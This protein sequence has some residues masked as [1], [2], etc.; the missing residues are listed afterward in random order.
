MKFKSL[1]CFATLLALSLVGCGSSSQPHTHSYDKESAEWVW[2]DNSSGGYDAKVIFTCT[3][4][5]EDTEG[6]T[7]EVNANVESRQTLAPTCTTAGTVLYTATATFE[8]QTFTATKEKTVSD[9][10]AHHFAEVA[11]EAYLKSPATCTED[12]VYYKSCEFCHEK[13]EETFTVANSKLGHHLVHH[14]A[15]ESTCQVQGN[16]EYYECDRCG[17]LFLDESASNETTIDDVL[18]PTAHRYLE[19]AEEAYLKSPAT[20]TEDAVYYKSC[21][22][23]HEKNEE[24]FTVANSKLGHHLIHHQAA[25]STCQVQGNIE[26]YECDRCNKLFLDENA[27]N[28]TTA[29]NVLLPLTHKM[30]YHAG[31]NAT[32][33]ADGSHA[34]YTCEYEDGVLYKDENANEKYNNAS[35]LVIDKLGHSFDESLKCSR[36]NR[37]L[38][39]E[40]GMSD[41]TAIDG[42][43]PVTVSNLGFTSGSYMRTGSEGHT[44]LDYNFL[45]NGGADIWM[46]YRYSF[47]DGNYD[48][49]SAQWYILNNHSED[50]LRIRLDS[51]AEN[52][53]IAVLYVYSSG[54]CNNPG[55]DD[56]ILS[57]P[58]GSAM[59]FFPRPSQFKANT[60]ITLH[61]AITLT[62]PVKN[63]FNVKIEAGSNGTLYQTSTGAESGDYSPRSFNIEMGEDFTGWVNKSIRFTAK[64]SEDI[65]ISDV[66]SAESVLVYKDAAG[67]IV[68]K[69]DNPG[70]A[71]LP[72]LVANNKTFIGWFDPQGNRIND[73]DAITTKKIV[74]PRFVD[75]QTNMFVPSDTLGN[76]FAAAKGGWYESTAFGGE[77]GGQLPTSEVN[78]RYDVYFIYQFV[79]RS[80]GDNYAIFGFPFDFIDAKTRVH[81][82]IDNPTNGN[83]V[84]YIYGGATN[85]GGAGGAGT[86]FSQAGFRSNGANLLVHMAIY[87]ASVNGFTLL[88]EITNLGDGQV[89]QTTREVT[90]NDATL[91]AIDSPTRN[92]FDLMK[93]NC[94]YRITDAF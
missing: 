71:K 6:H 23:C 34:Y 16:I 83:L 80:N 81:L 17:I 46:N 55:T 2:K 93:A 48:E 35:E 68:G 11:E 15:A 65:T 37:T 41:A 36:C 25:E 30:T 90:F 91:Y 45:A 76:E 54:Q 52:D 3:G 77:C 24:T 56:D 28:E 60:D 7:T 79:S 94:E 66:A 31:S 72:A 10:S 29:Q 21:E 32:C 85:L 57:G 63:I 27:T 64:R 42:I 1:F 61:F 74:T 87:Y 59:F 88:V 44:F 8:G 73:G 75:S 40:Y 22:F 33:T 38:K 67:N 89:Y 19:V 47:A 9:S 78:D 82:R 70:T 26:Y 39:E 92:I 58:N 4:C 51:R 43:D 5:S 84:G 14:E 20:C 69:L 53:G 49:A 50:G 13:S 18:L 86:N 12:A 62:D